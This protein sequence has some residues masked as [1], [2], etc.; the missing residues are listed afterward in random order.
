MS[1]LNLSPLYNNFLDFDDLFSIVD[2]ERYSQN[3]SDSY[4]PHNIEISDDN[5]YVIAIAV[6][7]FKSD[8]LEIQSQG[9]LLTVTGNKNQDID[10]K[11]FVYQGIS[12]KSFERKY[13][14]ADHV[15]V[16]NAD[17]QDGILKINLLKKIPESLKP[18]KIS[19]NHTDK[20]KK[21]N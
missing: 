7:G 5:N 12:R 16:V 10:A 20:L 19:I 18:K 14:L 4:P 6:P 21:I 17:L 13:N 8:D 3:Y 15:K 9:K 1:N 11:S 2:N